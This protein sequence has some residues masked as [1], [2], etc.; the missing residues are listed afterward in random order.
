MQEDEDIEKAEAEEKMGN[1]NPGGATERGF[2]AIDVEDAVS[3]ER[4]CA[5]FSIVLLQQGR[6]LQI[7]F[8]RKDA[9]CLLSTFSLFFGSLSAKSIEQGNYEKSGCCRLV[10]LFF[11]SCHDRMCRCSKFFLSCCQYMDMSEPGTRREFQR[12]YQ[13]TN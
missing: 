12:R 8:F 13:G 3:A 2:V 5:I 10:L 4:F 9:Y 1:G 11:K 6:I 7:L